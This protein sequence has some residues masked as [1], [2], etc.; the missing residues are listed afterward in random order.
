MKRKALTR[1]G[2]SSRL[3]VY[4]LIDPRDTLEYGEKTTADNLGLTLFSA[5]HGC[6]F[7]GFLDWGSIGLGYRHQ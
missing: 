1:S 5:E 4:T 2:E 7:T 3:R 6:F